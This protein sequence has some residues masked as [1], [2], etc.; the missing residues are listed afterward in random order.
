MMEK[1]LFKF[2]WICKALQLLLLL[3]RNRGDLFQKLVGNMQQINYLFKNWND[4]VRWM[5]KMK[6]NDKK[7]LGS[8][9]CERSN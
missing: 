6:M 2:D 8:Q 1:L 5:N 3:H 7:I 9:I 4:S